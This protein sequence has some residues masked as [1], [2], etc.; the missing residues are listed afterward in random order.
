[1]SADT[2]GVARVAMTTV[3]P[4]RIESG[5]LFWLQ[6][7]IPAMKQAA[8][9]RHIYVLGDHKTNRVMTISIWDT[10]ADAVA[11]DNSEIQKSLRGGLSSHV[12]DLPVPEMFQIK[13]E[14]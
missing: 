6:S 5:T 4:G 2:Q 12:S 3:E 8:G 9:F 7:I 13:L 1:M 10:E 11:W 14:A